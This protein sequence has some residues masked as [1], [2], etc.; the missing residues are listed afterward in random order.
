MVS[1]RGGRA[2]HDPVLDDPPAPLAE[3]WCEAP[4]ETRPTGA[5]LTGIVLSKS[6]RDGDQN[7]QLTA[8]A[9]ANR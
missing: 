7:Q 5:P 9:A 8:T 3:G 1:Q 4:S 6:T 2:D